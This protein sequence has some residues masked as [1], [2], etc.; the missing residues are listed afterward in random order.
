MYST[1]AIV[2]SATEFGATIIKSNSN[3]VDVYVAFALI[4][5]RFATP[6]TCAA[7]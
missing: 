4:V 5:G 1:T 2:Y 6:P 3:V 7:I